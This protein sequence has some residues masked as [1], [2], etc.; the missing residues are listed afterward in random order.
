MSYQAWFQCINEQCKERYPLNTVI[1]R[2][3]T[4]DSLLEVKHDVQALAHRSAREW[5]KLF[6]DRY[7]STEWPY[8]SGVWGKKEGILP[9][10]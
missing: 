6:E 8:G 10:I 5:M 2:C 1:Y 3:K 4:C 9:Q 7:K